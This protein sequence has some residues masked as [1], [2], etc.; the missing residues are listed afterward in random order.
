M[1]LTKAT[2]EILSDRGETIEVQFNPNT[3]SLNKD[4]VVAEIGIPGLNSPLLQYV[5]G[6]AETLDLELFC[7]TTR[8]GM[9]DDVRDVRE[10][11]EPIRRLVE[12]HPE[13]GAIPIIRFSWGQGLSFT[14]LVVRVAQSFTLFSPA[15]VP[16]RAQLE[17]RLKEF[18]TIGEQLAPLAGESRDKREPEGRSPS[19]A[20]PVQLAV[21]RIEV[22][23]DGKPLSDEV[24]RDLLGLTFQDELNT[25]DAFE[26]TVN[27]TDE[28]RKQCKYSDA[29]EFTPG[30]R[31][32]IHLSSA[33]GKSS[34][35]V[36]KGKID[37]VRQHRPADGA[38]TL[39]LA[40]RGTTRRRTKRSKRPALHLE[41]GKSLIEFE[42]VLTLARQVSRA[43]KNRKTSRKRLEVTASGKAIGIPEL[44]A[45]TL[46]EIRGEGKR[47]SG[48]YFVNATIHTIGDSGYTTSFECSKHD[49]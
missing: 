17:L 42:P 8:S 1:S 22:L 41:F 20:P 30:N 35:P 3:L 44:R 29:E 38:P 39:V 21:P 26:L 24:S 36:I 47:F 2:I 12:I 5:R 19:V 23:L 7:D 33:A 16:L 40:G 37:T 49:E 31:I 34:Q 48:H 11:T 10:F 9:A 27:N 18:K 46:I 4:V 15:G 28:R 25:R 32:E 45:G 6:E 13:F 14:A 43:D